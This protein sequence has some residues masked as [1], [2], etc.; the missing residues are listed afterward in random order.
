MKV[1]V[2]V[3]FRPSY[4]LEVSDIWFW[5]DSDTFSKKQNIGN[6]EKMAIDVADIFII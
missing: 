3:I 5:Y 6:G 4:F 1:E 2:E